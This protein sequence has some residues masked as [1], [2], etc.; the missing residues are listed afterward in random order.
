[1]NRV[2]FF[3]KMVYDY[4]GG[5]FCGY[6]GLVFYVWVSC[7]VLGLV[8]VVGFYYLFFFVYVVLLVDIF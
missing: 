5:E 3:W 6:G 4:D 7:F 2:V 1:M 8:G